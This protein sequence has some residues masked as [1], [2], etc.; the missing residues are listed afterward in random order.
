MELG[1]SVYTEIKGAD[2]C[3]H[4]GSVFDG[5]NDETVRSE[6][7]GPRRVDITLSLNDMASGLHYLIVLYKCNKLVEADLVSASRGH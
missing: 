6:T 5:E 1:S 2:G 4:F 7:R 3:A